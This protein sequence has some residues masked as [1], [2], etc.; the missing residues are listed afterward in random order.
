M[1][2]VETVADAKGLKEF[3]GKIRIAFFEP[4]F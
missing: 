2:G 4:R 3:P 1:I